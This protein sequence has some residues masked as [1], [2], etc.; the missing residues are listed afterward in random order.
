MKR[1]A[2]ILI[3]LVACSEERPR[4]G[5]RRPPPGLPE[6]AD[7]G[8]MTAFIPV[9]EKRCRSYEACRECTDRVSGGSLRFECDRRVDPPVVRQII[10]EARSPSVPLSEGIYMAIAYLEPL[11]TVSREQKLRHMAR[12][13]SEEMV[14]PISLSRVLKDS[15]SVDGLVVELRGWY[16]S[17]YPEITVVAL[18]KENFEW[19]EDEWSLDKVPKRE[20]KREKDSQP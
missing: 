11:M 3:G 9:L 7:L 13:A 5:P 8:P 15:Y 1:V 16:R 14:P 20:W 2:V 6:T 10:F 4:P 18:S 19:I 12:H 17:P